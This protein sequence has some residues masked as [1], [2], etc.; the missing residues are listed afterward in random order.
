[1]NYDEYNNEYQK[2]ILKEQLKRGLKIK[3][4]LMDTLKTTD[5]KQYLEFFIQATDFEGYLANNEQA[6]EDLGQDEEFKE[7][8]E[9][10]SD[11]LGKSK[12]NLGGKR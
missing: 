9:Q 4:T 2:L 11:R 12:Y 1:M 6:L 7:L 8:I 5:N 3:T 10:D